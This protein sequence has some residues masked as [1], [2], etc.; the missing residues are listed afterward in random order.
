[1][2]SLWYEG[3]NIYLNRES[4]MGLNIT[5]TVLYNII[6]KLFNV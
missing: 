2:K 4:L 1:M 5:K 6:K 3:G